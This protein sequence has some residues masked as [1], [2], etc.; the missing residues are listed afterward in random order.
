MSLLRTF[1]KNLY[2]VQETVHIDLRTH[3]LTP[4][5]VIIL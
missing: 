2:Y 5:Y 3:F 1:Y 4:Y